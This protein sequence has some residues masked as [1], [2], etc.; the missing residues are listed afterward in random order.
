MTTNEPISEAATRFGFAWILLCVA[1]ALHVADEAMTDFL[2]VYNPVAKAIR[3]RLP[4]FL[5]F[6]PVFTFRVWLTGLCLGILLVFCL[7]P[8]AFQGS[9]MVL[10]LAYPFAVIMFG[11]G[12]GHV[13]ASLCRRRRMPGVYS[14]PFLLLA[15][16]YLFICA[17]GMRRAA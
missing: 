6:P 9:R 11:N 5:P 1:L 15:S 3:Q 8:L 7:S 13:G 16:A 2:S 4:S 12:L 10:W 17:E 14:S